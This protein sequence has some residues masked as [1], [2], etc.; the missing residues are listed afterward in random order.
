MERFEENLCTFLHDVSQAGDCMRV[1]L[2]SLIDGTF[3]VDLDGTIETLNAAGAQLFGYAPE[4][5]LGKDVGILLRPEWREP[6]RRELARHAQADRAEC[7]LHEMQG[8]GRDGTELLVEVRISRLGR[9]EPARLTVVLRD[10]TERRLSEN[11]HREGEARMR[12]IV[13]TAVDGIITIDPRGIVDSMNPAAERMFGY[14]SEE[15][16]GQNVSRLMP[17]PDRE[18]HDSYLASY[19]RTGM[20][21][22]IGIGR[23]VVGQR[24]DGT[25]IPL[26]LAVSEV[27]FGDRLLFTGMVRDITERR[28]A[29]Q[30]L[31]AERER[32]AVTLRSIGDGVITTDVHGRV[33]LVNKVAERLTGWTQ[34]EAEGRPLIE[35]FHIVD[36]RTGQLADD[37][38][39]AVLSFNKILEIPRHTLLV[40]RDGT[41]RRIGDS[42]APIHD[43]ESRIIGAVLVFRDITEKARHEEELMRRDKLESLGILAGGIAHDFNNIL[44][45]ILCNLTLA[46]ISLDPGDEMHA[47]LTE[48]EKASVR[49]KHLTQQL[50]TFSKGG[51]PI[52]KVTSIAE[53]ITDTVSFA[54]SG[55]RARVRYALAPQLW[56]VEADEGQ[57]SQVLSN[58]VINADQAMPGGGVVQVA[59]SN[60]TL[61]TDNPFTLAPGHYVRVTVQD[62]GHGMP[63]EHL[64][65]I[66]DPYFTTKPR[67]SGLGLATSYSI[68]QRHEGH[69]YVES[70]V[71]KGS[72]FHVLLPATEQTAPARVKDAERPYS[73]RGRV[74][75]ME[76]NE[77]LKAAATKILRRLGYEVEGVE[78]GVEAIAAYQAARS[79]GEPFDVVL[80][81]LT[82]SG[83]MGGRE[84]IERL[85]E[86]DPLVRAVASSGYSTDP[87]MANHRDFGFRAAISKPFGKNELG[88][89]LQRVLDESG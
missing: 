26:D 79:R 25:L 56:A 32:L 41:E 37:P 66:F 18:R 82:I 8:L 57:I 43:R 49:A 51:A 7:V 70:E 44:S 62:S 45:E 30:A 75:L 61:R 29:E 11:A 69:I 81:D 36:E 1:L 22:I 19:L 87:I 47:T 84:T 76:D 20:K 58:L 31:A 4:D 12:A 15:V 34:K 74:L 80:M 27:R 54:M 16:V 83:G 67:G 9:G 3:I 21:K 35:V 23:E 39:Q 89:V 78:G 28:R 63:E 71:G 73:G 88:E 40:A 55:S 72:I 46:K 68:V 52:K 24:K 85:L 17:S 6:L 33:V 38:V 50:L 14:L 86:L 42:C 10:V 48:A 77:G 65:K 64:A 60:V 13:E 53:L 2:E 59:A 5:L